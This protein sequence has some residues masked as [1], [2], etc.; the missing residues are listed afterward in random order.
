MIKI[1]AELTKLTTLQIDFAYSSFKDKYIT[2]LCE[3]I[4]KNGDL[5]KLDLNFKMNTFGKFGIKT[6]CETLKNM[7]TIE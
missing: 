7:N 5:T 4:S 2:E 1:L 6:I 3:S